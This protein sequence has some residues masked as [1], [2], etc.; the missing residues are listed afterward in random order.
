MLA[1]KLKTIKN[2]SIYITNNWLKARA[3]KPLPSFRIN[4]RKNM[5]TTKH[6]WDKFKIIYIDRGK[7]CSPSEDYMCLGWQL[8]SILS[9]ESMQSIQ[10]TAGLFAEIGMLILNCIW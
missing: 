1:G 9:L 4:P 2:N 10:T 8:L 6:P 5:R 3:K 7:P